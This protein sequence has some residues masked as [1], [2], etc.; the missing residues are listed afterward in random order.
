MKLLR[1]VRIEERPALSFIR[2]MSSQ[3]ETQFGQ[4]LKFLEL[5]IN[6]NSGNGADIA[7]NGRLDR[8]NTCRVGPCDGT[9]SRWLD[10]SCRCRLGPGTRP[11]EPR[12]GPL[13][14]SR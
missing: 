12:S 5:S 14:A 7:C 4:R 3:H 1:S 9:I 2:D 6:E 10:R 8:H 13:P 11:T